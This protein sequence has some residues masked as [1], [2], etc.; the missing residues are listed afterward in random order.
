MTKV[1]K[2]DYPKR[3]TAKDGSYAELLPSGE[4]YLLTQPM[5]EYTITHVPFPIMTEGGEIH[6]NSIDNYKI[7]WNKD[8]MNLFKETEL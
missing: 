1:N 6:F 4:Q 7:I 3:L 5:G 8:G 2:E